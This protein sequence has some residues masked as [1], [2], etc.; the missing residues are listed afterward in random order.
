MDNIVCGRCSGGQITQFRRFIFSKHINI[1]RHLEL[2][3][4]SANPVPNDGKYN[5]NNSAGQ[6]LTCWDRVVDGGPDY[7]WPS[8]KSCLFVFVFVFVCV[9]GCVCGWLWVWVVEQ[10]VRWRDQWWRAL[11]IPNGHITR[12]NWAQE[13]HDGQASCYQW[14]RLAIHACD[15]S[16]I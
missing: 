4:A 12:M 2:E 13:Q 11:W 15:L 8:N 1:F 7:Q 6:G 9:G 10:L 3:I 5:W 14:D 16:F